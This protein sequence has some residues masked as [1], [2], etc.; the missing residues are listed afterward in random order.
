MARPESAKGV[1]MPKYTPFADSEFVKKW[2]QAQVDYQCPSVH[3]SGHLEPVP[4]FWHGSKA[5]SGR[6][7]LRYGNKVFC[8]QR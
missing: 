7:N 8:F 1:D 6:Y 3:A 2:Q 5:G 4:I